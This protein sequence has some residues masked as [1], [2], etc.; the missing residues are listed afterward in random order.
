MPLPRF[1]PG[2]ALTLAAA[3]P[4]F[5]NVWI[6]ESHTAHTP[7]AASLEQWKHLPEQQ[8]VYAAVISDGDKAV[9]RVLDVL[10]ETGLAAN[11]IVIFS[12]DNGPEVTGGENMRKHGAG[13][14]TWAS[15][16][17]TGGLRGRKRS[18]YEGGVRVPFFVR[19]P[20][21]IPAGVVDEQTV[22]SAV[23]L[24]PT[25]CAAAGV[26]LPSGYRGDGEN[27]LPALLGRPLERRKPIF[28]EWQGFAGPPDWWP[29][30]A[31][32]DGEWKLYLNADG[33][34]AELHRLPQDRAESANVAAQHPDVVARLKAMVLAWKAELPRQPNSDC[35]SKLPQP[36]P[37]AKRAKAARAPAHD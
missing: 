16:G 19:W 5:L 2:L 24:L 28:W 22:G 36:A 31:V 34:R 32:R 11:T 1:V 30:L 23:D 12:S 26:S 29:R 10:Q 3:L 15:V 37:P 25:L 9:G 7:S 17:Q 14:G 8:Q 6:H 13:W 18:L 4:F 20:G 33:S 35:V 27:L 21:R